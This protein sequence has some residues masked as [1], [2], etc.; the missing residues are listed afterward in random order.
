MEELSS[1]S[2][3]VALPTSSG[4]FGLKADYFGEQLF[5]ESSIGL[6]YGRNLGPRAAVGVGFNYIS[7][8]AEG[9]GSAAMVTFDAGA[10]FQL[11]DQLQTGIHIY[12]PV[13]MKFGKSGDEKLPGVYSVG[14]GYDVSPQLYIGTEIVKTEDQALSINGGIHYAF[15]DKLIAR[16]GI[17]SATSDFYLGFGVLVKS[18]RIDV[19]ASFHP[20][21]GTTPGLL[22]LYSPTK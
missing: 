6:V 16:G 8:N 2:I 20:Y 11:T 18:F 1:Y 12:N 21:L 15:A 22:F 3:A 10:I 13:G 19:T 14:L 5:H 9:Y 17:S 4:N 7:L